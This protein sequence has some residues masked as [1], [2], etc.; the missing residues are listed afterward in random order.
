ML[1]VSFF[2]EASIIRVA[3]KNVVIDFAVR[4]FYSEVVK[5]RLTISNRRLKLEPSSSSKVDY[6]WG[7]AAEP[8][9]YD[10]QY[11]GLGPFL[12]VS[13]FSAEYSQSLG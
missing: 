4:S 5:Q 6:V 3:S 12:L 10:P 7:F 9:V 1:K 2:G 8:H 13:V 11:F